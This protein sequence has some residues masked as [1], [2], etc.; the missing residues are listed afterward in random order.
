MEGHKCFVKYLNQILDGPKRDKI[1]SLNKK[2]KQIYFDN[3]QCT[4]DIEGL[5][6]GIFFSAFFLLFD[7]LLKMGKERSLRDGADIFDTE[8]EFRVKIGKTYLN[9]TQRQ[10]YYPKRLIHGTVC[11][12]SDKLRSYSKMNR[13]IKK[14]FIKSP[15]KKWESDL[16]SKFLRFAKTGHQITIEDINDVYDPHDCYEHSKTGF[17]EYIAD[18]SNKLCFIAF[19]WEP[20]QWFQ[21]EKEGKSFACPYANSLLLLQNGHIKFDNIFQTDSIHGIYQTSSMFYNMNKVEKK[22]EKID[23]INKK[24]NQKQKNCLANF[25]YIFG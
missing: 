9:I 5:S 6:C 13:I 12:P 7:S 24:H 22:I 4:L 16:I 10:I 15:N 23:N 14:F 11:L 8:R 21:N 18:I 1:L 20:I 17:I 25:K 2:L 3:E 19:F